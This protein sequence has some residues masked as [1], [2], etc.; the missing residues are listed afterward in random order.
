MHGSGITDATLDESVSD[1]VAGRV[2]DRLQRPSH[3][4]A[5]FDPVE[6]RPP[7]VAPPPDAEAAGL[8]RLLDTFVLPPAGVLPA[9][10]DQARAAVEGLSTRVQLIQGP[11]GT[12][13]TT[14]TALAVLLRVL[15]GGRPGDVVLLSAHTHTALDNLMERIDRYLDTLQLIIDR[16][17]ATPV[18]REYEIALMDVMPYTLIYYPDRLDGVNKRVRDAKMDIRGEWVNLKD[19]WIARETATQ[20]N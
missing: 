3:V 19:W 18:W 12:G 1:Y 15:V 6:P 10:P 7:Q 5:W 20:P 17:E 16:K 2:D 14:T 13:K 9:S 4:Y 8:S 11:P